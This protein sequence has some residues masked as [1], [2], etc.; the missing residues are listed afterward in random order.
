MIQFNPCMNMMWWCLPRFDNEEINLFTWQAQHTHEQ[1]LYLWYL[2]TKQL[3]VTTDPEKS[4]MQLVP[5][6]FHSILTEG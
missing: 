4:E 1:L 6:Y 3:D 2:L 5:W